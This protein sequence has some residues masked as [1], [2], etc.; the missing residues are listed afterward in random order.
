MGDLQARI[1]S[2]SAA[3]PYSLFF[4]AAFA[5]AHRA[6]AAAAIIAFHAALIFRRFFG[7]ASP[8]AALN[9][10]HR[11]LAAAEIRARPAADMRRFFGVSKGVGIGISP[12]PPGIELICPCSA[13]IFSLTVIIRLS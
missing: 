12:P 13:S 6:R 7:A 3:Q 8:F 4:P 1:V 10:A 11:A 9:L 2:L 5:F